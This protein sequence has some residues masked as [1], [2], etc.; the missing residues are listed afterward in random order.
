M[1]NGIPS[2]SVAVTAKISPLAMGTFTPS[3]NELST[4]DVISLLGP[5]GKVSFFKKMTEFWSLT[6]SISAGAMIQKVSPS[7]GRLFAWS[8]KAADTS[9]KVMISELM[10]VAV[11]RIYNVF[12]TFFLLR[13]STMALLR[14]CHSSET[15]FMIWTR[16]ASKIAPH[17]VCSGSETFSSSSVI[18]GYFAFLIG[19]S[20]WYGTFFSIPFLVLISSAW[21]NMNSSQSEYH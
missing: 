13:F 11:S 10:Y 5:S 19:C 9:C 6:A 4:N 12:G 20:N 15:V 7:L 8:M 21:S 3:S 16:M 1:I 14:G 17:M 18:S 2:L